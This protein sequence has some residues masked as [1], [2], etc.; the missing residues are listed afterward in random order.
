MKY[1]IKTTKT[2]TTDNGLKFSVWQDIAFMLYDE[3]SNYHVHTDEC[4]EDCDEEEWPY[5]DDFDWI[6]HHYYEKID[7]NKES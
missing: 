5:N 6:G 2:L 4:P 7:W 3:K 1:S